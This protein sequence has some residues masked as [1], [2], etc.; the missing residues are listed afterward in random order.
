MAHGLSN[1]MLLPAV[2]AFSAPGAVTRYAACARAMGL[3]VGSSDESAAGRLVEEL[4]R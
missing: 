2:T 1:A 4:R 3:K